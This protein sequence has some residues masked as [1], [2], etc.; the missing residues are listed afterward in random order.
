M[1]MMRSMR[2]KVLLLLVTLQLYS[3]KYSTAFSFSLQSPRKCSRAAAVT[4]LKMANPNDDDT[5][6]DAEGSDLAAEFFKMA[7]AKGISLDSSDYVEDGGDEDEEEPN[8]PQGAI[9]AF[10][11]YDT[12]EVGDKL[13]GNVS[14]TDDQLYSEVKERVLDTAG[15]FV[16]L[17]GG[18]REDEEDEDDSAPKVYE[19]PSVVPD[20]DLT[21]GEVVLLILE[22]LKNNDNPTPN[23]GVEIL[24]GYSSSSS[25]IMNEEGLTHKEYADFLKETEY[26]VLFDHQEVMID[27]GKYAFDGTKA[28]LTARLRVGPGPKDF[29]SCNFILT[30]ERRDKDEDEAWL[31]EIPLESFK[32]P[33]ANAKTGAMIAEQETDLE[34]S[35]VGHVATRVRANKNSASA[36]NPRLR[37]G[38]ERGFVDREHDRDTISGVHSI[39]QA[40]SSTET[41]GNRS[42][43]HESNKISNKEQETFK[44]WL[45]ARIMDGL[46]T[47]AGATL[48]T[49]GQLI[50]PPLH[51]TKTVILPSLLG[52]LVDILDTV[53]PH[54]LKDWFRILSSSI[55]HLVSVIRSTKGGKHFSSS[56]LNVMQDIA[57]VTSAPETR[58]MLIDTMAFGVKFFN[59]LNTQ[60]V[61]ILIDHVALLACRMVDLAAS[62]KTK[63]LFHSTKGAVQDGIEMGSDPAATLAFAEVTAHLCYALEDIHFSLQP[64]NRL[65]RNDENRETYLSPLQVSD[66]PNQ[67]TV[68]Q[69]ILSCLGRVDCSI[70][71]SVPNGAELPQQGETNHVSN[72]KNRSETVDVDYLRS[73]VYPDTSASAL[74]REASGNEDVV[75]TEGISEVQTNDIEDFE[76]GGK[77]WR[78]RNSRNSI[79]DAV[80]QT[81]TD[82]PVQRFYKTLDT[83][84]EKN[85]SKYSGKPFAASLYSTMGRRRDEGKQAQIL[86]AKVEKLKGQMECTAQER[87]ISGTD[88]SSSK[89]PRKMSLLGSLFVLSFAMLWLAFGIYGICA[90]VGSHFWQKG[91]GIRIPVPEQGHAQHNEIV[92]RIVREV[93]HFN[94]GAKEAMQ[95]SFSTDQELQVLAECIS[96]IEN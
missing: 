4:A 5:R 9:N 64:K 29:T 19:P 45:S 6:P 60:E 89:Q 49:T 73:N 88:H 39:N 65:H 11:G 46:N 14:L 23:K 52:L 34:D 35:S 25:Q 41:R 43:N 15:G 59:A 32:I 2:S 71:P 38:V 16:E 79:H 68:E 18:P 27:K 61:H 55:H 24:F 95:S 82:P 94:G 10:L 53:V 76:D 87:H 77:Y 57:L 8:I 92:F 22:V 83:F 67:P 56:F 44:S 17:V 74:S 3:C 31:V 69:V 70:R 28:F 7:Q 81:N 72:L 75:T 85:R 20:V 30:S 21:A 13:A 84:L 36:E 12:G 62:G 80:H 47:A 66:L 48:S 50:A 86:R 54:R 1:T 93:R 96:S 58:N 40:D 91:H 37:S 26:K 33:K 51:V 42:A 78:Q 63:Q 90:F